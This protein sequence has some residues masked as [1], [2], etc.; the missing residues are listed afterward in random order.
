MWSFSQERLI[1][2]MVYSAG[3]LFIHLFIYFVHL[4]VC[5]SSIC[6]FI[7]ILCILCVL[8]LTS[9]DVICLRNNFGFGEQNAGEDTET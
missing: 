5:S 1:S 7:L 3:T 6:S 4:Y 9:V 2:K 8:V